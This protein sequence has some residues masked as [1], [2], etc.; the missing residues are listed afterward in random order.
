MEMKDV[1]YR[2]NSKRKQSNAVVWQLPLPNGNS[3]ID[4]A[5]IAHAVTCDQPACAIGISSGKTMKMTSQMN[6]AIVL[7]LLWVSV[8][9]TQNQRRMKAIRNACITVFGNANSGYCSACMFFYDR[10]GYL[11]SVSWSDFIA[12]HE[13]LKVAHPHK[14]QYSIMC[15]STLIQYTLKQVIRENRNRLM[16]FQC[17]S[18]STGLMINI[19]FDVPFYSQEEYDIRIVN[20]T[21]EDAEKLLCEIHKVL[22]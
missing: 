15:G 20:E 9:C 8:G 21:R 2:R 7:C 16:F 13:E 17:E 10:H 6:I 5:N 4:G 11:A 12:N 22:R 3:R 19:D 18:K 1:L 14:Q